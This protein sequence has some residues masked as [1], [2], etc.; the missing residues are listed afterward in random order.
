MVRRLELAQALVSA[1]RVLVL[2]E[3]TVGLDPVARS[4]VWDRIHEVR[5]ETGM[6]VLVTTHAMEEAELHCD[7]VALLHRGR[8]RAEGTPTTLTSALTEALGEDAT[9]DD[10]FRH[11]TGDTLTPGSGE[12]GSLRDVRAARRTARRVG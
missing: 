12:E 2:D 6:T 7:R 9:L 10:V 11:H 1:P 5:A 4:G 8:K 3:P